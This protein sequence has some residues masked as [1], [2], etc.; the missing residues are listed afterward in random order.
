MRITEK[1]IIYF[2]EEEDPFNKGNFIDG[3]INRRKYHILEITSVN[4]EDCN[5]KIHTTPKIRYPF[6]F[7]R[8]YNIPKIINIVESYEKYDGFNLLQYCYF[9]A[10]GRSFISY[11]TRLTLFPFEDH[12]LLSKKAM[13][14]YK[15]LRKISEINECNIA[16]EV[17]GYLY[18]I[19]I[20]YDKE[21]QLRILFGIKNNGE[22]L[23]P[24]KISLGGLNVPKAEL[25]KSLKNLTKEKFIEEYN[26][27][28]KLLESR[29]KPIGKAKQL[30]TDDGIPIRDEKGNRTY[31][32]QSFKGKEGSVWYCNIS[33]KTKL[34]KLKPPSIE[35]LHMSVGGRFSRIGK[36][37]IKNTLINATEDLFTLTYEN[38]LP[39]L[40][41]EYTEKE[42][43]VYNDYIIEQIKFINK[44]KQFEREIIK[45]YKENNLDYRNDKRNT[46][47]FFSKYYKEIKNRK[48]IMT[49]VF[50]VLE[51][52][53]S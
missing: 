47:R 17:Y 39:Y 35:K 31:E 13:E 50:E 37:A 53:F 45:L 19:T 46:M 6:G 14:D 15:D 23:S 21:I 7:K 20:I 3:K 52:F 48:K 12:L 51:K 43:E 1:D 36:M 29:L 2:K 49:N 11:K 10:N 18:P 27:E 41:E 4:G 34:Y 22:V 42:I 33:G 24:S 25:K 5:Q 8:T 32:F 16:F 44:K 9:D 38:I 40:R 26:K 30:I 28:R